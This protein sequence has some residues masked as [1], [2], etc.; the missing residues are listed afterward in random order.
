MSDNPEEILAFWFGQLGPNGLPPQEKMNLW[1]QGRAAFD[2][3]IRTRFGAEIEAALVGER[4]TWAETPRGR[5]ALILLLDQ[6]TRNVYRGTERAFAG[7][8]KAR[9]LAQSAIDAGEEKGHAAIERYFCYMP[10]MHAE[11]LATQDRA[12]A[13]FRRLAQEAP[14]AVKPRVEQAI[15]YAI[16]HRTVIERFGRFPA[17]NEALGRES[18]PEEIDLLASGPRAGG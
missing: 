4:D 10:F 13:C 8:A 6:F 7:D 9:E 15:D 3:E 17:R 14:P 11:E 12:V 5:L 18:T 1:F 2:E 16:Q